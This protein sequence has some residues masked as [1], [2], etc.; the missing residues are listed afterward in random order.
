MVLLSR[1]D[2]AVR[3]KD[4]YDL[5]IAMIPPRAILAATDLSEPSLVALRFA[6]RLARHCDAALHVV[7][8]EH[9]LLAAA[10]ERSGIHLVDETREELQRA[11]ATVPPVADCAPSLHVVAGTAGE[12]I[13]TVAAAEHADLIVVGSHG[14]SGTE[15]LV[16][17]ST[18]EGLLRR[19]EVSVLVV[20]PGWVPPRPDGVDLAGTGPIIAGVDMTASSIA[21]A[22]AACQLAQALGTAVDLVYVVPELAVPTRWR[23]HAAQVLEDRVMEARKEL[24]AVVRGLSCTVP[25]AWN[26][27]TGSVADRLA[28]MA[29]RAADRAPL[30]VLGKKAPRAGGGAP[31]TIAYRVLTLA[32]VPVL[33]VVDPES[34]GP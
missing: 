14:M 15:K 26:V 33:M 23:R 19:S 27:E 30:L 17:G 10:A 1:C 7:H 24:E 32:N 16:F 11:M 2:A 12:V 8:A 28:S 6:A 31:G 3:R 9:P 21:G 34:A 13:G 29:G 20:P 4:E 5:G 22:R 25:V 18:T